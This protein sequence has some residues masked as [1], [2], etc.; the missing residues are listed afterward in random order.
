MKTGWMRTDGLD[1]VLAHVWSQVLV[2]NKEED[3]KVSKEVVY[4]SFNVLY[5]DLIFDMEQCKDSAIARWDNRYEMA[6]NVWL[7]MAT[8]RV[9]RVQRYEVGLEF[10]CGECEE[11]HVMSLA[12]WQERPPEVLQA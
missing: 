11:L 8:E 10:D 2:F 6:T 3:R 4:N 5:L 9:K 12:E 1:D 7:V